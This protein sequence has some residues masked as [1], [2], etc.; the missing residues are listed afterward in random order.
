MILVAI[1]GHARRG[2]TRNFDIGPVHL[3]NVGIPEFALRARMTAHG[4]R[5]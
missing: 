3:H 4:K 5:A 1:P 2:R